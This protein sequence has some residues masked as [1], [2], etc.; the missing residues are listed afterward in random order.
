MLVKAFVIFS[1]PAL[2]LPPQASLS[3]RYWTVFVAIV[4]DRQ[5]SLLPGSLGSHRLQLLQE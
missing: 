2:K 3:I 4:T 5:L 1:N